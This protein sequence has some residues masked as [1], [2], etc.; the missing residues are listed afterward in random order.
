MRERAADR[1]GPPC[2]PVAPGGGYFGLLVDE[3]ARMSLT[4]LAEDGAMDHAVHM[5]RV[6]KSR[7][8]SRSTFNRLHKELVQGGLVACLPAADNHSRRVDRLCPLAHELLQLPAE[9]AAVERWA[10]GLRKP[11][12]EPLLNTIADRR[13]WLV[14][15]QLFD[16]PLL[17][18]ELST[19]LPALA[20]GTLNDVLRALIAGGLVCLEDCPGPDRHR[21]ALTELVPAL[22]R[23]TLLAARF[24]RQI[25]PRKAPWLTGDL[26]SFVRLLE[27][28]PALHAPRQARGTVLLEVVKPSWEERCWP[29]IEVALR[30]G[31]VMAHRPETAGPSATLRALPEAWGQTAFDRNLSGIEIDGDTEL[32]HA[33]LDVIAAVVASC[34]RP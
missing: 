24:R 5:A 4:M 18:L 14:I 19:R 17:Y 27:R 9:V 26:S 16:R 1:F 23:V 31:R 20:E 8:V 7:Y 30:H 29:A 34:P 33:L 6:C 28:A 15:R 21:Y 12:A 25:T 3:N 11:G 32:A 13:G 10:S 2:E 22:T